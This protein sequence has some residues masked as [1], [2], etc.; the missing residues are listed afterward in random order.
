M[1]E[2]KLKK[3]KAV[4]PDDL[5][6]KEMDGNQLLWNNDS[7]PG[8]T[9]K[10]Q[11]IVGLFDTLLSEIIKI[12]SKLPDFNNRIVLEMIRSKQPLHI[13]PIYCFITPHVYFYLEFD[14]CHAYR[15]EYQLF[16]CPFEFEVKGA[17]EDIIRHS[18]ITEIMQMP[19][20][21]EFFKE[22]LSGRHD[23]FI[24]LL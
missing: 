22:V 17:M 23:S 4:I 20:F 16:E 5:A 11:V 13:S 1:P 6:F 7:S 19:D 10:N 14:V 24:R 3:T 21:Q 15:V 9:H 2:F 18:Y 12:H 8:E